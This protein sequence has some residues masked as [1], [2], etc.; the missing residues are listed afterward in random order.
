VLHDNG[1]TTAWERPK[2]KKPLVLQ[3]TEEELQQQAAKRDAAAAGKS[4]AAAAAASSSGGKGAAGLLSK[5][6]GSMR[7]GLTRTLSSGPAPPLPP[8]S[9]QMGGGGAL[10]SHGMQGTTSAGLG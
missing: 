1:V 3:Q 6:W 4:A 5:G 9:P 2:G 8:Q 10:H 7:G